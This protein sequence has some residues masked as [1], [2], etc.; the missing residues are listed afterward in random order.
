[1]IDII[2]SLTL[3]GYCLAIRRFLRWPIEAAPFFIISCTIVLFYVFAYANILH[4]GSLIFILLGGLCLITAPFYLPHNKAEL[5]GKYFTP[6]TAILIFSILIFGTIA[7]LQLITGW[8]DLARWF[9]NAKLTYLHAGFLHLTDSTQDF[10][11]PPGS[12]L[13][14]YLFFRLGGF[15]EGRLHFAHVFLLL[16]PWGILLRQFNWST[17]R[18]AVSFTLFLI[19]LLLLFKVD[20]GPGASITVDSATGLFFGG[21]LISYYLLSDIQFRW[22]YLA[23]P[24]MALILFKP[25]LL[26]FIAIISAVILCDQYYQT[27]QKHLKLPLL[28][29]LM[30]VTILPFLISVSWQYH[31]KQLHIAT[32]YSVTQLRSLVFNAITSGKLHILNTIIINNQKSF[33]TPLLVCAIILLLISRT[34]QCITNQ[35]TKNRLLIA[36]CILFCGFLAYL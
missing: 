20:L 25:M 16:T 9:P 17:V 2:T 24:A 22:L 3:L 27:K 26:P 31:L 29:L 5:L 10:N 14:Y 34:Y 7:H 8:D 36:H 23:T 1:M 18:T 32:S 15:S 11:Y 12:A 33:I 6:G 19:T 4:T 13:F 35:S 30:S 28:R 21:I